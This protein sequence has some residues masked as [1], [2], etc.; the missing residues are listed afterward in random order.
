[1]EDAAPRAGRARRPAA[2]I[3][4]LVRDHDA[5]VIQPV[6]RNV[7]RI[8][9]HALHFPELECLGVLAVAR[10]NRRLAAVGAAAGGNAEEEDQCGAGSGRHHMERMGFE[11]TTPWLQ[12]RCSPN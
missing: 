7:P 6:E 3:A 8:V 10:D 11:P 2:A 4:L 12:T 9:A 1:H 5:A